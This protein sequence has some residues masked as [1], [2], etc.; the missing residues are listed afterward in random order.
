MIS[1]FHFFFFFLN[2]AVLTTFSTIS[3]QTKPK[4]TSFFGLIFQD[5]SPKL[6]RTNTGQSNYTLTLQN[7]AQ[8][9][10]GNRNSIESI[11]QSRSFSRASDAGEPLHLGRSNNSGATA[12]V[13]T[14]PMAA[15][16]MALMDD[17]DAEAN[18]T[19]V[20]VSERANRVLKQVQKSP[21]NLLL[22]PS[23]SP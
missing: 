7:K 17:F 5:R 18:E 20:A 4:L 16:L 21:L 11:S 14:S 12:P 1:I 23:K 9:P 10:H 13:L 3:H 6:T 2:L 15:Q 19:V 8:K 22:M